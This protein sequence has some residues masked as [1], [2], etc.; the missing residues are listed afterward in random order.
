[1]S[2]QSTHFQLLV[3]AHKKQAAARE[4]VRRASFTA[5]AAGNLDTTTTARLELEVSDLVDFSVTDHEGSLKEAFKVALA[6]RNLDEMKAEHSKLGSPDLA[7]FRVTTHHCAMD[8]F[9]YNLMA[10]DD[11]KIWR[12]P[13]ESLAWLHSLGARYHPTTMPCASTLLDLVEMGVDLTGTNLTDILVEISNPPK[14]DTFMVVRTD[15][16]A[17][18]ILRFLQTGAGMWPLD[19]PGVSADTPPTLDLS[20][21]E[22]DKEARQWLS[23]FWPDQFPLP[24][25]TRRELKFPPV[26][27][28]RDSV[29]AVCS[30]F[31]AKR[32]EEAWQRRRLAVLCA[33]RIKTGD[34]TGLAAFVAD[35]LIPQGLWRGVVRHL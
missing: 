10:S 17:S 16:S 12:P 26:A 30:F 29:T 27:K 13:H 1:M 5:L 32:R 34:P 18:Y 8:I 31:A 28:I 11:W 20:Q 7:D 3:A 9:I 15:H 4:A 6:T 21:V 22:C 23:L 35:V 24:E 25:A 2:T 33:S 19:L 14:L